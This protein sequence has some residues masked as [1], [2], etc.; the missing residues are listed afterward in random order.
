MSGELNLTYETNFAPR[1]DGRY[2]CT[3]A[4]H[5]AM[6]RDRTP[7]L[8]LPEKLTADSFAAWQVRIKAALTR[9]LRMPTASVQPA[10]VRLSCMQRDG[11]RAEKWEFYPDD[12]TVVPF[13]VLIPNGISTAPAVLCCLGDEDAKEAFAGEPA[14][15]HPNCISACAPLG[16][17]LVRDGMAV[18]IFETPGFGECSVMADP[19]LGQTQQYI[20]EI[21]C[22]GLLETGMGYIG[23]TV[24]QR[25]QFMQWLDSFDFVDPQNIAVYARGLGTEAAIAAGVLHEGIKGLVL[26]SLPQDDRARYANGTEQPGQTMTQDVG[27]WHIL[28]GKMTMFGWQDLCAAFAPRYLAVCQGD[29]HATV[30]RAYGGKIAQGDTGSL[31]KACFEGGVQH[32]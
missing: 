25:L 4:A 13:L 23:L 9:Q 30:E 22:H 10:P 18:F 7:D 3:M 28:P 29:V 12:Y 24:F 5:M 8:A 17:Q 1:A 11:Y 26:Q 15:S 19:A 31:L 2:V 20:R 21:L 6:L 16:Q 27:K 32:V 14:L